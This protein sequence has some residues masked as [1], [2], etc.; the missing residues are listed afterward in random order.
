MLKTLKNREYRY[1]WLG[2]A[3][4][5][6]GDQFH[7]IALPWLVLTMTTE[8]LHLGLVLAAAGVPRGVLM[9]VGGAMAD[10]LSPRT[11]MLVSNLA[12]FVITMAL[13]VAIGTGEIRL[14]MV[15]GVAIA[16]GVVS[17][18]FLPAAEASLPRV[19]G[20]ENLAA[21]NSLMMMADQVSKFAGPALAGSVIAVFANATAFGGQAMTG[22]AI[23]FAL[24]GA[25]FAFAAFTL[26][27]MRPL[28]PFGSKQHP[29]RDVA[30]GLDY[31]WHQPA[32]KTIVILIALANLL[33]TGPLVVGLPVLAASRFSEGAAAF[34]LILSAFALGSLAGMAIAGIARPTAKMLGWVATAIFP[35]LGAIYATLGFTQSTWLAMGLMVVAGVGDGFLAITVIA[36]LQR[37][38]PA[39]LVGRV[40]S[41]LMLSMF[42][43]GPLSQ[44]IAGVVA[45]VSGSWLF[46][47]AALGLLIPMVIAFR[48][49]GM[50]DLTQNIDSPEPTP[51]P[52]QEAAR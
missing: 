3:V 30:E 10:R 45:Q 20:K 5:H 33:L 18:F 52:L 38:A 6:L 32:I 43:L 41:F 29:L 1:L 39:K 25:T 22:I 28:E 35:F 46:L 13:V 34:G 48:N 36:T 2:Q 19:L 16:F 50:W 26:W 27:L 24:D 31:V 49:R 12:R 37:M 9:L 14:W 47:G 17:G 4:S 21:G 7:L 11:L 44:V 42:G 51:Q 23:A 40:M 8:V 15:Y